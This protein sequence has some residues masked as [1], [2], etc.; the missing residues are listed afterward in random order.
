MSEP[1]VGRLKKVWDAPT[2]LFHWTLVA[3]V[4]VDLVTGFILPQ[5]WMGLHMVAGIGIVGLLVFRVIWAFYGS[6]YSRLVTLIHPPRSV[7]AYVRG[8]ALLRPPHHIGHNPVGALM[9]LALFAVLLALTATGFIVMGGEEKFGPLGH[10]IPYAA[11]MAAK[12]IHSRLSWLL[13]AMIVLHVSGVTTTSWLFGEGLIR[14]MIG[15]SKRIPA[16]EPIPAARPAHPRRAAVALAAVAAMAAV[17]TW[18][19]EQIP[20]RGWH[21]ISPLP[22]YESS[23]G[24]CHAALHPSLLPAATWTAVMN[25]L[26][27]HFGEDA[28]LANDAIRQR[29]ETYLTAHAAET[30]ETEASIRFRVR[31]AADPLRV[32]STPY[33]QRKHAKIG[34]EVF[35]QRNVGGKVNCMACHQDANTGRF[36][37]HKIAMP[38]G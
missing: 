14:S 2:R 19:L 4:A 13:I 25:R 21:A 27:D 31:P 9:V 18:G 12:L 33:W 26:D 23:C 15:G 24:S 35:R 7:L 36:D 16:G 29:I 37:D 28:S 11:G 10:V 6:E 17:G 3:L 32:T 34:A 1:S 38:K 5:R 22:D 8:L 20:D 30:F